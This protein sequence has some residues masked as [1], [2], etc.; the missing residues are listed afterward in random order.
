MGK[1][2]LI[3]GTWHSDW[4]KAVSRVSLHFKHLLQL[5]KMFSSDVETFSSKNIK[6]L[7]DAVFFK[8]PEVGH[9][10]GKWGMAWLSIHSV[11]SFQDTARVDVKVHVQVTVLVAQSCLT[12]SDP[13]DCSPPDSSCPWDSPGKS[14][15]VGCRFLL[16]GIFLTQRSNRGLLH[17]RRILYRLSP[18]GSL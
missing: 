6:G 14:T 13:M 16:Q 18:Q 8:A 17:S 9:D 12:L 4:V 1:L 2:W 15:G 7:K 3:S 10:L 11:S 5:L